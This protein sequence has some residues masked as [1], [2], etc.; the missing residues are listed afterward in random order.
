MS[1]LKQKLKDYYILV[2]F[3]LTFTVVFSSLI[4]YLLAPKVEFNIKKMILLF[5]GGFGIVAAA[6]V[7][8]Q[9]IERDSD[10]LMK[11]TANRPIASKRMRVGEGY[12]VA[13]FL[14]LVGFTILWFSFNIQAA[15]LALLSLIIY[16][17][18]YTPLKKESALA[19]L[20]GAI[21]G[22]LPCLVGWVAATGDLFL[23]QGVYI[24][25]LVLFAFQFLWQFPHFWAIA[26]VSY[27]DYGRAGFKLLPNDRGPNKST[28]LQAVWYSLAM[29]PIGFLPYIIGMSGYVSMI[30]VLIANFY[31]FALCIRLFLNMK[32]ST[33]RLIMFSSYLYL[34]IVLLSWLVD[35]VR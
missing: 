12:I 21:P 31:M 3:T 30:I 29:I 16:A 9:I 32:V 7:L 23:L 13:F 1:K 25:G 2:K 11:R 27:E 34:P 26:W 33:A 10:A 4:A 22:A 28:A 5:V 6:N 15:L 18:I 14:T 24:G 20:V 8:N 17:Y 19:V 35:K